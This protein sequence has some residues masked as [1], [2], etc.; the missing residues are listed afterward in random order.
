MQRPRV[1]RPAAS[2]IGAHSVAAHEASAI[3]SAERTIA[4]I[5]TLKASQS[6]VSFQ[7]PSRGRTTAVITPESDGLP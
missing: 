7:S 2:V 3:T 5:A 6:P 1:P 4:R